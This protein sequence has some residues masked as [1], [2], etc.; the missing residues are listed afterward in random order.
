MNRRYF[1]WIVLIALVGLALTFYS[2]W[3]SIKP[4]PLPMREQLSP[5]PLPPFKSYISGV[6]IVEASSENISIG[7]PINRIVSRV[8]VTVGQE[9]KKGQV[10]FELENQDLQADLNSQKVTYE[11]ALAKL[12]K[13]EALPRPE[14]LEATE[15][16]LR[17][18]QVELN[19]AKNQYDMVQGLQDSRALSQQEINR[20]RFAY[21][22]AEANF[23][24]AQANLNK[25]KAGTWK[26]DLQIA[27]LETLQAK[28]SVDR[29]EAEI[30][31]TIIRSPI[32]GK[33]LQIKIHAGEY[34]ATVQGPLMIVGDTDEMFVKVSI[35]Q[36]DAPYFRSDAPA[37]A[38]LRGS[39]RVEFSLE[40]VRLEPYLVSKQNL[41]N[42]ITEKVDTRVLQVIYRIKNRNE[43]IFV[44]QQMDVFIEAEF[45]S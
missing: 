12:K 25:I 7:T 23:Q 24:Q 4:P 3:Q 31:R 33:V 6:G 29:I 30:E 11:I 39:G 8:P 34:P 22:Q 15:A 45:P 44:G 28:A 17:S 19:Q 42:E 27:Y 35:N 41:T 38:F 40:F 10:L 14:E 32:E 1:V 43:K 20:R 5:I 13:L 2:M 9:V 36:F 21:E 18:A 16:A 26:P 37:V